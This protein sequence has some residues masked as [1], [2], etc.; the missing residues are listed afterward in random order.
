M[1]VLNLYVVYLLQYM[2]LSI[3]SDQDIA[4]KINIVIYLLNDISY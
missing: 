4:D 3:F 2:Y 1:S